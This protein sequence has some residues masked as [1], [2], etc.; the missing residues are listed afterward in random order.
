MKL[1]T[2]LSQHSANSSSGD[3]HGNI[4]DSF[5]VQNN[6]IY[7][8]IRLKALSLGYIFSDDPNSDYLALP[9]AQLESVLDNKKIP[10]LNNVQPLINLN[11]RTRSS[12][13]WDHVIDN[14]KPNYIFHESCHAIARHFSFQND[15]LKTKILVTLL[16]ESFANTCEFLAMADAQDQIHL[17][18]LEINSY[19]TVFEDRTNLKK[20]I[21]KYGLTSIFKFMLLSYLHSNFLNDDMDNSTLKKVIVLS[22]FKT[23]PEMKVLKSLGENAF[24]LNPRFRYNTTEMY[25]RLQGIM[26]PVTDVLAFDYFKEI[27]SNKKITDLIQQLAIL[28]GTEHE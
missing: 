8:Q 25:L 1:S 26:A 27:T 21:E 4:G 11:E 22:D 28:I 5:L 24:L 3:I 16:E 12:L 17:L 15:D 18:F 9:M 6:K 7:R 19:F 2:L 14:I 20:A 13:D 23:D 10:Y